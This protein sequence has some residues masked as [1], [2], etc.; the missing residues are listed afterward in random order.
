M[1]G[2]V[3][4]TLEW[5][6]YYHPT[7]TQVILLKAFQL[8]RGTAVV[9]T[10]RGGGC[11]HRMRRTGKHPGSLNLLP[12]FQHR[13]LRAGAQITIRLTHPQ[14]VGKYYSFTIRAGHPPLIHV[15]CLAVG[16]LVPGPG[17]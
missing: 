10:C 3:R 15:T 4:S 9:V 17:C 7:Y 13:N 14:W 11:P 2:F 8:A 6:F 16:R 12:V 1:L 5:T